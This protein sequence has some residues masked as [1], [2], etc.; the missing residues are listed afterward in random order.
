M[1]QKNEV[2]T[3]DTKT[4]IVNLNPQRESDESFEEYKDRM[5]KNKN[6]LKA[7]RIQFKMSK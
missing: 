4:L 3:I 6:I 1:N 7:K 2:A 5:K